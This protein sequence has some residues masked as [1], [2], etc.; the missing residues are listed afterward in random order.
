MYILLDEL[1]SFANAS[2]KFTALKRSYGLCQKCLGNVG[3]TVPLPAPWNISYNI[4]DTSQNGWRNCLGYNLS[5][6]S[7]GSA[8]RDR[9]PRTIFS[10]HITSLLPGIQTDSAASVPTILNCLVQITIS[11]T[12]GLNTFITAFNIRSWKCKCIN[13]S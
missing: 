11:H 8:E 2:T 12:N 9:Q 10:T 1:V 3:M 7:T 4:L 13:G 6:V 5:F